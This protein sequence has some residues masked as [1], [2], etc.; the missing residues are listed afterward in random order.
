MIRG[1]VGEYVYQI[2][3]DGDGGRTQIVLSYNRER[4]NPNTK[5][6]C[7]AR[8]QIAMMQ[9][10]M[11]VLLPIIQDSFQGIAA[12]VTSVN[13]FVSQNMPLIQDF[14]KEH[15]EA[16]SPYLFPEKGQELNSMGTFLLSAGSYR[17]P[18][19]LSMVKLNDHYQHVRFDFRV[20][21][22]G[23]RLYDLRKAFSYSFNDTLNLCFLCDQGL[24]LAIGLTIVQ[25]AF[26][27]SFGDYTQITSANCSRVF[28]VRTLYNEWQ[29][30]YEPNV[31]L[32][33]SWNAVSHVL[34]LV[35]WPKGR[36]AYGNW[37]FY[38]QFVGVVA[39]KKS[40]NRYLRNTCFLEPA[41]EWDYPDQ[42]LRSPQEAYLSW[43]SKY[44]DEPYDDYFGKKK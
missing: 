30:N 40:G 9:R 33:W 12:G 5:Y 21:N 2:R 22:N 16:G 38:T 19:L 23:S 24:H 10:A 37:D 1:A 8:M 15:W 36:N 4:K 26:N 7:L 27:R 31:E 32:V 29:S 17:L 34:S 3:R 18:A 13:T 43:D 28:T 6:Q 44:N 39:S 11:T 14:C 42:Y 25:L 35:V 41:F 20:P